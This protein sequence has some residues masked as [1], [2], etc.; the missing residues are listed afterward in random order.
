[1]LLNEG[2]TKP[3]HREG[4][5]NL[6]LNFFNIFWSF[7]LLLSLF[8]IFFGDHTQQCSVFILGLVISSNAGEPYAMLGVKFVSAECKAKC[9]AN[10]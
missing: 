10:A 8:L 7:L 6:Y 3:E 4:R 2:V 1:M 9:K 5:A